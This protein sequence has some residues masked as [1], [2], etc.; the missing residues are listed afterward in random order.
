MS[1]KT[2]QDDLLA[3]F[4]VAADDREDDAAHR[5]F[6]RLSDEALE[7]IFNSNTQNPMTVPNMT[8]DLG[9]RVMNMLQA[10]TGKKINNV[11]HHARVAAEALLNDLK[12]TKDL[13][14]ALVE[15]CKDAWDYGMTQLG[16]QSNTTAGALY[17]Q[18]PKMD[19]KL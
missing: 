14:D 4:E 12:D 15:T 5:F 18:R 17:A 3:F 7:K 19:L 9:V 2:T 10:L 6:I 11:E 8:V 13:P 1:T 16:Y